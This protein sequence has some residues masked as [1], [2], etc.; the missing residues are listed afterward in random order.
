[1]AYVNG[2]LGFVESRG[3]TGMSVM[4]TEM[5]NRVFFGQRDGACME[6]ELAK[7]RSEN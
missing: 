6:S 3:L 4:Y 1:M 5:V 7:L 2:S